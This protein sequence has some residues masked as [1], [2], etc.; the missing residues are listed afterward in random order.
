[1]LIWR[2]DVH[3]KTYTHRLLLHLP[4]ETVAG[5]THARAPT[6]REDSVAQARYAPAGGNGNA[7][8]ENSR[9]GKR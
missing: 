3:P 5:G 7:A 6:A 8:L 2:N 4:L 1:M 9:N